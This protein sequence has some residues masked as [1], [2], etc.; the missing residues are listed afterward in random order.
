MNADTNVSLA[1]IYRN[2][3]SQD[4]ELQSRI[5][6]IRQWMYEVAEFGQPHFGETASRLQPLR[7]RLMQHFEREDE[8]TEEIAKSHLTSTSE[9]KAMRQQSSRD[10]NRL[11]AQLDELTDRLNLLDPPFASWQRAIEE[12]EVL[13]DSL[14][15]HEVREVEN[16][17]SL[18]PSSELE[19]EE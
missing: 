7:K 9:V 5:D 16:L 19:L 2:W 10:R 11:F 15:G 6:E 17:K 18:I 1:T 3:L 12:V 13:I 4:R 8:M 14:E